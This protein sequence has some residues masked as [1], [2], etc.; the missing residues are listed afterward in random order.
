MCEGCVYFVY[1]D[2]A[3]CFVCSADLDEDDMYRMM[4]GGGGGCPYYRRDEGE[5]SVVK[6]QN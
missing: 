6:K 3:A 2:E 4:S 1:D 5:Y